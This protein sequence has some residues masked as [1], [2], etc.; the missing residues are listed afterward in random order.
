MTVKIM[1]WLGCTTMAQPVCE[2]ID[3]KYIQ[4]DSLGYIHPALLS[5]FTF[6][7]VTVKSWYGM[8]SRF[9][10]QCAKESVDHLAMSYRTGTFSK[11]Q[12]LL[13]FRDRLANSQQNHWVLVESAILEII[14]ISGSVNSANYSGVQQLRNLNVNPEHRIDVGALVDN[15]DLEVIIRWD[16][17]VVNDFDD[18]VTRERKRTEGLPFVREQSFKEQV[19]LLQI[20]KNLLNLVVAQ[21]NGLTGQ[22][23]H[24]KYVQY[25]NFEDADGGGNSTKENSAEQFATVLRKLQEEWRELFGAIPELKKTHYSECY[26]VN[27]MLSQL[28]IVQQV[29]YEAFMSHLAEFSLAIFAAP[30]ENVAALAAAVV[31]QFTA[32]VQ[33]VREA[34]REQMEEARDP[35]WTYRSCLEK[36]ASAVELLALATLVVAVLEKRKDSKRSSGASKK[37]KQKEERAAMTAEQSRAKQEAIGCV[38]KCLKEQLG[39]LESVLG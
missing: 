25:V 22:L 3:L 8:A 1:H 32:L 38:T 29:P 11:L 28:H 31:E 23:H 24:G 6:S 4:H 13:D 34:I 12:E 19:L 18:E 5:P 37:S 39:A 14:W 30:A 35:F 16:P 17:V 21:V 7:H 2:I 33:V 36:A 9:Y 26:L 27:R 10:A 20:R 15:R